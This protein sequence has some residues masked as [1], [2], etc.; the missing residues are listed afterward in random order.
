MGLEPS[1]VSWKADQAEGQRILNDFSN[2]LA[3]HFGDTF[4]YE[5]ALQLGEGRISKHPFALICPEQ[6]HLALSVDPQDTVA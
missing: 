1:A 6:A 2:E 5:L 4:Y 3:V